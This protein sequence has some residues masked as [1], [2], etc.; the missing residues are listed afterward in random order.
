MHIH[1]NIHIFSSTTTWK[2]KLIL[3]R[4]SESHVWNAVHFLAALFRNCVTNSLTMLVSEKSESP[5][6]SKVFFKI[7]TKETCGG[8]TDVGPIDSLI[9]CIHCSLNPNLNDPLITEVTLRFHELGC[10]EER[11]N[12]SLSAGKV[13]KIPLP[14]SPNNIPLIPC[15]LTKIKSSLLPV[16][17]RFSVSLV[18]VHLLQYN[19]CPWSL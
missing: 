12:T 6:I 9:W 5:C 1:I 18:R 19:E 17:I 15:P 3:R 2:N 14:I 4:Q 16:L 11:L 8:L 10:N 7:S 13:K